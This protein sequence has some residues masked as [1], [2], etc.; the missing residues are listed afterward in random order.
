MARLSEQG[1]QIG[2]QVVFSGQVRKE[3]LA[4]EREAIGREAIGVTSQHLTIVRAVAH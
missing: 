1:G 4:T 3:V 2:K